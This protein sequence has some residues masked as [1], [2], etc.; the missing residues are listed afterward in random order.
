MKNERKSYT[1]AQEIT[2]LMLSRRAF[3]EN[4]L[5]ENELADYFGTSRAPIR[6]A[7]KELESAGIVSRKQ[8]LGVYLHRPTRKELE[9]VYDLR[10]ALEGYAIN[11]ANS[12]VRKRDLQYLEKIASEFTNARK[13]SRFEDCEKLNIDFHNKI[14]QISENSLLQ[15]TVDGL[16]LIQ[17]AFTLAHSVFVWNSEYKTPFPHEKLVASLKKETPEESEKLMRAHIQNAKNE[18]LKLIDSD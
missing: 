14:I 5:S 9:E 13:E 7:L 3:E 6:D 8:K 15:K 2:E 11:L 12:N 1:L 10:T 16:R 4:P 18:L 17:R